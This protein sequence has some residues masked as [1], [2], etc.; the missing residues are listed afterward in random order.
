MKMHQSGKGWA[1]CVALCLSIASSAAVAADGKAVIG[2]GLSMTGPLA[3][4]SQQ[5][6]QG[7]TAAVQVVNQGGGVGG[8]RMLELGVRDH[9]GIPSEAV[10]VTKRLIEEDHADIVD[11]ENYTF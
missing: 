10:A 8:G 1:N 5:Y 3:F 7:M 2:V 9:K 11:I 6:T 4:L